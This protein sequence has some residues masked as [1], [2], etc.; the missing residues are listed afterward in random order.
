MG[1]WWVEFQALGSDTPTHLQGAHCAQP[2]VQRESAGSS[3]MLGP[4]P[5]PILPACSFWREVRDHTQGDSLE[6][7]EDIEEG[8]PRGRGPAGQRV[9]TKPLHS[10]LRKCGVPPSI[11]GLPAEPCFHFPYCPRACQQQ[12]QILL[13]HTSCSVALTPKRHPCPAPSPDDLPEGSKLEMVYVLGKLREEGGPLCLKSMSRRAAKGP[14]KDFK[15]VGLLTGWSAPPSTSPTQ[16]A[17]ALSVPATY[18]PLCGS[19]LL[20]HPRPAPSNTPNTPS[21]SGSPSPRWACPWPCSAYSLSSAAPAPRTA[22]PARSWRRVSSSWR[23]SW[24]RQ[25]AAA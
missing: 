12:G 5:C 17:H 8:M 9:A 3:P 11:S 10:S 22:A 16:P 1:A 6:L 20:S 21:R 24:R 23:L 7:G 14:R 25:W 2:R 19:A 4:N 18:M 15:W 13:I